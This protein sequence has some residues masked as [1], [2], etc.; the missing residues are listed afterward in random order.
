MKFRKQI[1]CISLSVLSFILAIVMPYCEGRTNSVWVVPPLL[2]ADLVPY[3]LLF[4]SAA[5]LF[6]YTVGSLIG[7]RNII[8]TALMFLVSLLLFFGWSSINRQGLYLLGFRNY[9]KNILTVEE[10]RSISRFAQKSIEPGG[11]LWGPAKTRQ[12]DSEQILW[13]GFTNHTQIQKLGPP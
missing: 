3:F 9:A 7:K 4:L 1:F 13:S 12:N 2:P 6:C 11:R 5:I 10:W 8:A